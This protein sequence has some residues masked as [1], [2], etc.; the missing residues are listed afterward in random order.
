M[1]IIELKKLQVISIDIK[2]KEYYSQFEELLKEL[3]KKNL[4]Q[5]TL[6]LINN[7][8]ELINSSELTGIQLRKLIKQQQTAILKYVEKTHKI[9]PKSYYQT[10]W[11]L[12]GIT[13]FGLPIGTIIGL[14]LHNMGL[15]GLGL[16]IG[17]GIGIL[18]GFKMD[19]KALNEG[20]QLN[21]TLKQ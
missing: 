21:L 1:N 20:R 4:P 8:I 5:N 6:A 11:L 19:K 18:I 2:L 7:N 14:S 3:E 10:L 12:L 9:V 15:L 17:M 16:P 13:A